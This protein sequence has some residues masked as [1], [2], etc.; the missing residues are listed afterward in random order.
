MS[1]VCL[2]LTGFSWPETAFPAF[3]R[4]FSYIFPSTFAAHAFINLSSAGCTL[5]MIAPQLKALANQTV[6]YYTLAWTA[7]YLEHR[8]TTSPD[9][10]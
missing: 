10:P 2:F 6:I 7:A 1:P 8:D 5:A 3:W 4:L 9:F